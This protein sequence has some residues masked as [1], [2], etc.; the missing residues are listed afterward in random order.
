VTHEL[1]VIDYGAGNLS[2][3]A[4]ALRWLGYDPLVTSEARIVA[5]AP[6][7]VLPGVGAAA[8]IMGALRRLA[9][10]E[11]VRGHITAGKPFLGVCMGMQVLMDSS[12]EDGGQVCLG[13]LPGTVRRLPSGSLKIPHM[14]WNTVEQRHEHAI[15][16]GIP[17]ESYFYF[18]HSYAVQPSDPSIVAACTAYGVRFTSVVARDNVVGTQ[19]HPEKSGAH[20]LLVY[21]NFV[22]WARSGL[23]S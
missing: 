1:V 17:D 18:V 12:E 13:L 16:R 6:I 22:E 14:G 8:Q 23:S 3:V 2:S 15:W 10:D 9:L 19:F 5:E 21:R 7:L 11:A 20:G 4:K